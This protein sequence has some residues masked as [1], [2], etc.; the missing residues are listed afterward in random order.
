MS[1]DELQGQF[2]M[3]GNGLTGCKGLGSR[4]IDVRDPG[5]K[6]FAGPL[7]Y[8]SR[9]HG[10]SLIMQQLFAELFACLYIFCGQLLAKGEKSGNM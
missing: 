1:L 9:K 8:P 3:H 2:M 5:R 7:E 6:L 10:N 4:K